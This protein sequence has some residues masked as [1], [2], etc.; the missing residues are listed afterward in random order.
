MKKILLLLLL[1]VPLAVFANYNDIYIADIQYDWI[2]K[3]ALEKE[4][5]IKE[6]KDIVFFIFVEK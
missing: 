6:V 1:S 4:E 2:D 3:S 5:I